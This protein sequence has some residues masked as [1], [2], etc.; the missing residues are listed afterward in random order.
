MTIIEFVFTSGI[1]EAPDGNCPDISG[2][3]GYG[4]NSICELLVLPD[5]LWQYLLLFLRLKVIGLTVT[6]TLP[7]ILFGQADGEVLVA[8]TV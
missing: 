5:K 4:R 7:F 8:T 3:I 2:C 6:V 1:I